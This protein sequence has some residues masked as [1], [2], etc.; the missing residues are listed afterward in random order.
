LERQSSASFS[1][2]VAKLKM[3]LRSARLGAIISFR[4]L[5]AVLSSMR[6]TTGRISRWK[7]NGIG[8]RDDRSFEFFMSDAG[9]RKG[10]GKE[11]SIIDF[12][13]EAVS[14]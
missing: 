10:G 11:E 9:K 1:R 7:P 12:P 4:F 13:V 3:Q 6:G 8:E 14:E 2:A 5:E